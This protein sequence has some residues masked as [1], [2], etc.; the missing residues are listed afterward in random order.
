MKLIHT[1]SEKNHSRCEQYTDTCVSIN[2]LNEKHVKCIH[3][4]WLQTTCSRCAPVTTIRCVCVYY[5]TVSPSIWMPLNERRENWWWHQ[6]RHRD[7]FFSKFYPT[8]WTHCASK[9]KISRLF[10]FYFPLGF[11]WYIAA[12][13]SVVGL[14]A[15]VRGILTNRRTLWLWNW[16]MFYL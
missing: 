6:R 4:N 5:C 15:V 2:N 8:N 1:N 7:D 14:F 13:C 11:E 10:V 9:S 16:K 3:V 12:W